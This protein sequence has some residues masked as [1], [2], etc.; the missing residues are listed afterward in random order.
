M[1][2]TKQHVFSHENPHKS[3]SQLPHRKNSQQFSESP[4]PITTLKNTVCSSCEG[5]G[6]EGRGGGLGEPGVEC[7]HRFPFVSYEATK[8]VTP[9][10][11]FPP[12][13]SLTFTRVRVHVKFISVRNK[14]KTSSLSVQ[15]Q[16][17]T[18]C[19][20]LMSHYTQKTQI[21]VH[22]N[23]VQRWA[24]PRSFLRTVV[25]RD[26]R[27]FQKAGPWF[28]LSDFQAVRSSR[29]FFLFSQKLYA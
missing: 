23:L 17:N 28:F 22:L 14:L 5:G 6:G 12:F 21:T 11:S 1:N 24:G 16:L 29:S 8:R 20:T 10:S 15:S 27:S 7:A 13:P 2:I 9:S 25:F 19:V 4:Q 18:S 26:R 3:C